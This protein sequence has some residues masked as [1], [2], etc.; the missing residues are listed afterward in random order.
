[1]HGRSVETRWSPLTPE[2]GFPSLFFGPDTGRSPSVRSRLRG[3]PFCFLRFLLTKRSTENI[4]NVSV[5]GFF[6]SLRWHYPH[7][8]NGSK[9][10]ASSQPFSSPVFIGDTLSRHRSSAERKTASDRQHRQ[11]L[12]LL[13]HFHRMMS[14]GFLQFLQISTVSESRSGILSCMKYPFGNVAALQAG[15]AAC[16]RRGQRPLTLSDILSGRVF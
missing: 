13:L 8:V 5:S 6:F 10:L 1:M 11:Y 15:Q 14:S 12:D 4:G 2:H 7:Q 16:P 9:H 3:A